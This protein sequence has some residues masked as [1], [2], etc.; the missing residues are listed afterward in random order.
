MGPGVEPLTT[1]SP[2]CAGLDVRGVSTR[3]VLG[4]R[5]PNNHDCPVINIHRGIANGL[6]LVTPFWASVA[7]LVTR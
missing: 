2:G 3:V 1:R 7:W 5:T 4:L 6:L